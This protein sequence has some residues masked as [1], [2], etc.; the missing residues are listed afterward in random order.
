MRLSCTHVPVKVEGPAPG[1]DAADVGAPLGGQVLVLLET[2]HVEQLQE[3]REIQTYT[4][5][6]IFHV[7]HVGTAAVQCSTA[8]YC[9]FGYDGGKYITV[10]K[11]GG[12]N[13]PH[14]SLFLLP[15]PSPWPQTLFSSSLPAPS[16]AQ[17]LAQHPIRE[18]GGK[19]GGVV[20]VA[21][22]LGY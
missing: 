17:F 16:A 21:G 12:E 4:R 20:T 8:R 19:M 14:P 18:E 3:T 11:V 2:A 15:S 5:T 7:F 13:C 9:A 6:S 1:V 10:T 22:G